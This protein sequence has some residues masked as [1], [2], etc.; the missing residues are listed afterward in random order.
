MGITIK[1]AAVSCIECENFVNWAFY[2]FYKILWIVI[3]DILIRNDGI[4]E[5][6]YILNFYSFQIHL[7]TF[8]ISLRITSGEPTSFHDES[9]LV[10][11]KKTVEKF[12]FVKN[13][14]VS[15]FH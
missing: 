15:L 11:D 14:F 6:F 4:C 9:T 8:Y 2:V 1:N 12:D 13:L 7:F 5:L 10:R 3:I